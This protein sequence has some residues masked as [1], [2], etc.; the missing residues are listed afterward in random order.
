MSRLTH[1][2]RNSGSFV[3]LRIPTYWFCFVLAFGL[4]GLIPVWR[5]N[6]L[7]SHAGRVAD[8]RLILV[9]A[10]LPDSRLPWKVSLVCHTLAATL[11]AAAGTIALHIKSRNHQV[12]RTF[13]MRT[14]LILM[15]LCGL[16]AAALRHIEVHPVVLGGALVPV[17]AYPVTCFLAVKLRKRE[18]D[19]SPGSGSA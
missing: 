11:L 6:V 5:R 10:Y 17:L 3:N 16:A 4:V 14:I 18:A 13:G 15:V 1:H 7:V 9:N 2:T 12:A 19:S 8:L